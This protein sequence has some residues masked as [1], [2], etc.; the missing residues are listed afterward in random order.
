MRVPFVDLN[1]AYAELRA[2]LD[3]AARRVLG[4]G[5]YILGEEVERFEEEFARY[6][7]ARHAV[8][9]GTGLDAL[10]LALMAL[11]IGPGD[12][13]L[14][15]SN[16]YIATW[17]AVS[18]VGATPVPV[19][20]NEK[21]FNID[22]TVIEAAISKRTKA[23]IP[24]HLYGQPAE[25]GPILDASRGFG[26]AIVEDAAQAHGAEYKGKRIGTHADAT[27]FSFYP[28]KNLGAF[29]DGGAITTNRD[30]LAK[31]VRLLRNYGSQ[32]KHVHET[33]GFNSRLDPLQAAMLSV[34]L[35]R[36]DEWNDRRREVAKEYMRAVSNSPMQAVALSEGVNPVWHVFA[37]RHPD[38]DGFRNRLES[39]GIATM[40]HYPV[41]PHM[42]AAYKHLKFQPSS[43]P[44]AERLARELVSLPIG[45]HMKPRE[46]EYVADCIAKF[47]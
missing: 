45:P 42:Q 27:A 26:L 41:P 2:E 15:P 36:L 40:V 5:W 29:G 9:V 22:E 47:G 3:E 39:S 31:K 24:V 35:A 37:V 32:R 20:P 7:G 30:D 43:L 4:S 6:C 1:A 34:K 12:E 16:T 17:F 11:D 46:V 44:V 14:V 21:T 19:E 8:G 18:H 10:S 33:V 13:V 23:I 28:T 38:R 25:L